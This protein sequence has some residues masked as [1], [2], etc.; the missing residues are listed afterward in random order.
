MPRDG[1]GVYTLPGGN[2]VASGTPITSTWA[3]STMGDIASQLNNVFTRDGLIGPTAAFKLFDGTV[4]LP[5]MT[6]TAQQNTGLFRPTQN[7][8][9]VA[10]NGAE[11]TRFTEQGM[12]S[13]S[14]T[15]AAPVYS[16]A[17]DVDSGLFSPAPGVVAMAVNGVE[18]VR[19]TPAGVTGQ[20]AVPT[21][22]ILDFAGAT[23]PAGYLVCDG[24]AVSRTTYAALFAVIASTYGAGDGSTTFNVPD[25]R[26]YVTVGMGGTRHHP[27]LGPDIT[28]GSKGGAEVSALQETH[29]PSH[30]HAA[31]VSGNTG[32]FSQ[33][34]THYV[35]LGAGGHEHVYQMKHI[36]GGSAAG[37][38][39]QN[40]GV[41]GF[42]TTGGGVHSHEGWSGGS[43]ADHTHYFSVGIATDSRG[44]GT[45]YTNMQLSMCVNKIIKT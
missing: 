31:T 9:G 25:L 20:G 32:G 8:M 10:V 38:D 5:G 2:P 44:S 7:V 21:G 24:Q 29:M 41:T 45:P 12:L 13:K 43:S 3:N 23:A 4:V 18:V 14:G 36:V 42:N 39:P 26:R 19:W 6:F 22:T 37:G 17:S 11:V 27:T 35:W 40:L 28:L 16:F 33:D 30:A 1:S 15:V 34:H